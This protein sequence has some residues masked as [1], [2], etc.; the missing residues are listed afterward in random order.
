MKNAVPTG[1]PSFARRGITYLGAQGRNVE[2]ALEQPDSKRCRG[3]HVTVDVLASKSEGPS[4][5]GPV[6]ALCSG[7]GCV[8]LCR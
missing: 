3:V 6:A 2:T 4:R 7:D 1:G 5:H 8:A